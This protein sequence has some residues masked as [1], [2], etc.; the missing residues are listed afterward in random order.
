MLIYQMLRYQFFPEN[1]DIN[2]QLRN[3]LHCFFQVEELINSQNKNL[4][5]NEVLR[6]LEPYLIQAD[7]RVEKGKKKEHKIRV[8]VLFGLNSDEDKYFEPDALSADSKIVL[9]VEAGRAVDN[10]QFLKDIF[11][12][13]MMREV[14]YLVMA[15]RNHYRGKDDFKKV[16]DYLETL[17]AS[18]RITLPLL[19]ILIIGY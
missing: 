12:A 18:N 10:N 13:S 15:V 19:G 5:S 4:S 7:M 11:K 9:E 17:Y 14:E 2:H 1:V 16:C 8:Q 3:I 6:L